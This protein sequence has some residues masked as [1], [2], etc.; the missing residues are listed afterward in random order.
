MRPGPTQAKP[1]RASL[2]AGRSVALCLFLAGIFGCEED[3]APVDPE[4]G[5]GVPD[6]PPRGL[7][8]EAW[9]ARLLIDYD[10]VG[11]HTMQSDPGVG[12]SLL[13]M[14][15]TTRTLRDGS[16]L[17]VD[18]AY[19]RESID[20]PS[21]KVVAG[22]PDAMPSYRQALSQGQVDA[23]VAHLAGL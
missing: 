11:C 20:S 22:F 5:S 15:G 4:L 23:I 16:T 13:D 10:C 18:D 17:I 19:V 1:L 6:A 3:R 21:A 8:P 7:T 12:G 2:R 14:W 9:G